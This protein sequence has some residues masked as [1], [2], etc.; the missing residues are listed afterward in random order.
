MVKWIAIVALFATL[1]LA[2]CVQPPSDNNSTPTATPF[3]AATP[4][5]NPAN[6]TAL[7]DANANAMAQKIS[8]SFG[9][10]RLGGFP[11]SDA[12][13]PGCRIHEYNFTTADGHGHKLTVLT[14]NATPRSA[15]VDE[16]WDAL[17][18]ASATEDTYCG[19][20]TNVQCPEFSECKTDR[21]DS[22]RDALGFGTCVVGCADY[23]PLT[24]ELNNACNAAGGTLVLNDSGGCFHAPRCSKPTEYDY[25]TAYYWPVQCDGNPWSNWS[26]A[27]STTNNTED[28]VVKYYYSSQKNIS[29]VQALDKKIDE[30]VCDA[31][32]CKRGDL[33]EATVFAKDYEKMLA[34]GWRNDSTR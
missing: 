20:P 25:K 13:C 21:N 26:K 31:C 34:L 28:Y 11:A 22:V 7:A 29:I 19:G 5:I 9:A 32:T 4:T 1:V 15:V 2:G 8:Q 12:S 27:L 10:V 6:L 33:I 23:A 30:I 14:T 16:F 24:W 18:S 3:I 17:N